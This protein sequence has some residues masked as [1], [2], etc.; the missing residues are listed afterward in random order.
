MLTP[1]LIIQ[2]LEY[3]S[4]NRCSSYL[5]IIIIMSNTQKNITNYTE[6]NSS[7]ELYRKIDEYLKNQKNA[8]P[9]QTENL[10]VR[11]VIY[12][13]MNLFQRVKQYLE[14]GF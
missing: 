10:E 6:V 12:K 4:V 3:L 11:K 7:E 13:K 1:K 9:V 2:K 14:L 5:K 8:K